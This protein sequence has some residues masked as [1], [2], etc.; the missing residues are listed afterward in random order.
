VGGWVDVWAGGFRVCVGMCVYVCV[1][2]C[3]RVD[4]EQVKSEKNPYKYMSHTHGIN[5]IFLLLRS[6]PLLYI[7]A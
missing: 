2:A 3:V 5:N 4:T 7:E 6:G 1:C